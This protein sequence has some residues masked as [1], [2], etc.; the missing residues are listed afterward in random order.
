MNTTAREPAAKDIKDIIIRHV[1][2][3]LS[4]DLDGVLSDYS[5]DAVLMTRSDTY[6]GPDEIRS[7]FAELMIHFPQQESAFQLDKLEVHEELAFI[8]WHAITPSVDVLLGSDTFMIK[9]GKILR[10][11]FVAEL[12][13]IP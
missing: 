4:N 8:I 5:P 12:K 7:F 6:T 10:Q 11:T 13:F 1:N 2:A 3:F 9:D